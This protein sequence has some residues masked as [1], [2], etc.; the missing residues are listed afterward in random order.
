MSRKLIAAAALALG[1]ASTAWAERIVSQPEAAYELRLEDVTTLPDST[2]GYLVFRT[3]S[4]C[5]VTSVTVSP[6]TVYVLAG[7]RVPFADFLR[8][9]QGYSRADGGPTNTNVFVYYDIATR[10]VN[11]VVL[12]HFGA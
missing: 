12:N 3:C 11:R 10:H 9:A 8:A 5:N 6:D 1:L 4:A 2:A 7:K